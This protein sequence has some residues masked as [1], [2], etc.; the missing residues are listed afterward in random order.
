MPP[1]RSV[2][3]AGRLKWMLPNSSRVISAFAWDGKRGVVDRSLHSL[4]GVEDRAFPEQGLSFH[5]AV[6]CSIIE[7]VG[8]E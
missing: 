5:V 4:L 3:L 1:C 7:V 6:Q 8:A 2:F